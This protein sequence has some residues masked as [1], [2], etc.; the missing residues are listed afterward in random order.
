MVEVDKKK[1]GKANRRKGYNFEVKV[2]KKFEDEGWIVDKWTNNIDL[3]K[4]EICKAKHN[5]F[6]G[7]TGFPDFVIMKRNGEGLYDVM[8]VECKMK[9]YLDK[10]ETAKI[11]LL[12]DEGFSCFVAYTDADKQITLRK[13]KREV[14]TTLPKSL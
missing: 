5:R 2:R 8:L 7:S 6:H 11:H 14:E 10:T 13:V 3:E 1:Q 9:K 12:E 4:G